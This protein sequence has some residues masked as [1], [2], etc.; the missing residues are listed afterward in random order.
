MKSKTL[1]MFLLG[2]CLFGIM[3]AACGCDDTDVRDRRAQEKLMKEGQAQ[4]GM[5]AIKNFQEKK[6]LKMILEMRDQEKLQTYTYLVAEQTGKLVFIGRSIG[7][8]IPYAT[9][10]TNPQ[11]Y[12]MDGATLPQA[13]PNGLFSPGSADGT[14]ILMIDPKTGDARPT[15]IEPRIVVSL[16]RLD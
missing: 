7:F 16:F 15:Y 12:Y 11:K 6:L 8:G 14:W 3:G 5:P 10:Y 9:Q 4:A 1:S 13:D 2:L